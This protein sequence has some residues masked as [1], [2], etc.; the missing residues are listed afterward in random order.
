MQS[1]TYNSYNYV[2]NPIVDGYCKCSDSTLFN[3]AIGTSGIDLDWDRS[4]YNELG[5]GYC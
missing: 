5:I 4:V 3:H 2:N 1:Y